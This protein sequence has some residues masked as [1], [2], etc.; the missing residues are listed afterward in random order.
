M[1]HKN[2]VKNVFQKYPSGILLRNGCPPKMGVPPFF[3][4]THFSKVFLR[5]IFE[6]HFHTFSG[7]HFWKTPLLPRY[8]KHPLGRENVRSHQTDSVYGKRG[9]VG[10]LIYISTGVAWVYSPYYSSSPPYQW[11]QKCLWKM[12]VGIMCEKCS[13]GK[14]RFKNACVSWDARVNYSLE[15]PL[16]IYDVDLV[17]AWTSEPQLTFPIS[18]E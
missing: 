15:P 11:R 10:I 12:C 4:G 18:R 6:K 17:N 13:W 14:V 3:G 8:S 7:E 1:Y 2:G 16:S 9:F 5:G